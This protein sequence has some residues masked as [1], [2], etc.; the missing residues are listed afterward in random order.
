MIPCPCHSGKV[1]KR[2][3]CACLP[4]SLDLSWAIV[5]VPWLLRSCCLGASDTETWEG[6]K[7]PL[8]VRTS[9]FSPELWNWSRTAGF[10]L[11]N[12]ISQLIL[13]FT[14][15]IQVRADGNRPIIHRKM[16]PESVELYFLPPWQFPSKELN[17]CVSLAH[18]QSVT[19]YLCWLGGTKKH[20]CREH[21][22]DLIVLHDLVQHLGSSSR[23]FWEIMTTV[24]EFYSGIVLQ[25]ELPHISQHT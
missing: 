11:E 19:E 20:C 17:N 6:D 10:H 23:P 18:A 15:V 1:A 7:Q 22:S 13:C 24:R 3:N 25:T 9:P 21:P 8:K 5:K 4:V 2:R 12:Y 14:I 16:D